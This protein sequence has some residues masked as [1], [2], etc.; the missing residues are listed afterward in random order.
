MAR[1]IRGRVRK[2]TFMLYGLAQM[3]MAHKDSN[4]EFV[5]EAEP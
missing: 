2:E 1:L 4:G 3:T 5:V